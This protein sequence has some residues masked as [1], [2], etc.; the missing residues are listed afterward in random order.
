MC[1][2]GVIHYAKQACTVGQHSA[3]YLLHIIMVSFAVANLMHVI[4]SLQPH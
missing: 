4:V 1:H 2:F 3:Q